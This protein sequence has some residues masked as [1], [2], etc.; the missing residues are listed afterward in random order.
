[1]QTIDLAPTLLGYFGLSP[2]PDMQGHD[3]FDTVRLDVPVRQDALFGMFGAHICVTDGRYVYMRADRPDTPL[4]DYT[5]LPLH[6]R[7]MYA[8]EE[9]Q[10]LELAEPFSF[11]KGCRLLKI[12]MPKD[13]YPCMSVAAEENRDLLFD[14]QSDPGQ[15]YP[16]DDPALEQRMLERMR[17]LMEENDAPAEQY[18]RVGLQKP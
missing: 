18:R 5:L 16:L 12:R 17:R 3:L 1:M 10:D 7:A 8:P 11:T 14:L 6:Q 9:L 15:V 13:F 2:T 4:Y